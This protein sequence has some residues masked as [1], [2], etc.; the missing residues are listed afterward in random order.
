MN[1]EFP[2]EPQRGPGQRA[3]C[4]V[5]LSCSR[6]PQDAPFFTEFVTVLLL[7]YVLVFWPCGMWDLSSPTR[8]QTHTPCIGRRSINHW[9]AKEVP[10]IMF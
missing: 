6:H 4:E 7:I 3:D 8:H 5:L 1:L 10:M 9:T 2:S